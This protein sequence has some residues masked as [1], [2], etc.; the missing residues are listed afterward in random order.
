ML[1]PMSATADP[2]EGVG[3]LD[4]HELGHFL[5]ARREA[6]QPDDVGL[7]VRSRRRT[8]GLRREDVAELAQVSSDY[9]ARLER[10]AGPQPSQQITAALARALRLTL[11]ERDHLFVLA[12]HTATHHRTRSEHVSPGLMRVLDRLADT[13]AQVMGPAGETLAQSP[14]AVALL[15]DQ[16][17]HTGD[18]RSAVH[19]WFTDPTSRFIH[20]VADHDLHATVY[21]AQ[22]RRAVARHGPRSGP[23]GI[24]ARLRE[25]SEEFRRLWDAHDVSPA[26]TD[27][28]RFV[29]PDVGELDLHCQ[30]LLDPDQDQTLL[31]FTATPG[32]ASA[33]GLALLTVLGTQ[34]LA[35]A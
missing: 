6:L 10:G 28:K 7:S 2:Q 29:H 23:A 24:A 9:Y 33:D 32:A 12:G 15:G 4:R 13:P 30:V 26:Y 34:R 20:P 8:A 5:R 17:H 18:A 25:S 35:G 16:T 19:R 21:V 1:D 11:A 22:L 3:T 27:V 31:V 14:A